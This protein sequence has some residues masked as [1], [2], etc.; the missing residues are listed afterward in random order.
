MAWYH[1]ARAVAYAETGNATLA[2]DEAKQMDA[3]IKQWTGCDQEQRA[4]SGH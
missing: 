4:I 3:A 1:W 2:K